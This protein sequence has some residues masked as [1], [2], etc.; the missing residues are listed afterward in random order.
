[1]IVNTL[2]GSL[3]VY[4]INVLPLMSKVLS[5]S[6]HDIIVKYTWKHKR[7]HISL[8]ILNI[9]KSEGGIKLVNFKINWGISYY[10][11]EEIRI[12]ADYA[13]DNKYGSF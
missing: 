12:L 11:F 10:V 3:F 4:K 8:E 2:I 9:A 1:M 13:L 7:A 5:H 6:L